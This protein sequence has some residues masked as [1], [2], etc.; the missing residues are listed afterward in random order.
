M[1]T[2]ITTHLDQPSDIAIVLHG[3]E[4]VFQSW[5]M[6]VVGLWAGGIAENGQIRTNLFIYLRLSG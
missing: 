3:I 1:A 5:K 6:L 4:I 2:S